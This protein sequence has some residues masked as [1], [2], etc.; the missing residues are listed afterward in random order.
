[1]SLEP[2]DVQRLGADL[3]KAVSASE[4]T[5]VMLSI[6]TSLRTGVTATEDLLRTTKIGITV[7]KYKVH[8]T[9][10][11]ARAAAECVAKWRRDVKTNAAAGGE[12]GAGKAGK[13]G[14]PAGKAEAKV[15]ANGSG[16]GGK[17]AEGK[18]EF[19]TSV[20]LD[21]R[22]SVTDKVDTEVTGNAIRDNCLKLMYDGLANMSEECE[23]SSSSLSPN[24]ALRAMSNITLRKDHQTTRHSYTS[25]PL[26]L[27]LI[28]ISS[29]RD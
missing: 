12:K 24:L 14:S 29:P 17:A 22:T 11:V 26:T 13:S 20:P 27:S 2:K 1:M 25:P 16:A 19:K 21:K 8:S 23:S 4:P 6:L 3:V 7:N 5:D 10:E 28:H 15:E 18:K 9:P